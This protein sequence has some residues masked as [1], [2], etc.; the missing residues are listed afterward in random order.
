[1]FQKFQ[2]TLWRLATNTHD[3]GPRAIYSRS[4]EAFLIGENI[5]R[6]ARN[7]L[8]ETFFR[9]STIKNKTPSTRED[10]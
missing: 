9:A 6:A 3:S 10:P 8:I 5:F 4:V 2:M 1:M 7:F